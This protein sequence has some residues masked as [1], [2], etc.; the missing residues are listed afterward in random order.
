MRRMA[1]HTAAASRYRF[2]IR[3]FARGYALHTP[4]AFDTFV[5]DAPLYIEGGL[6]MRSFPQNVRRQVWGD[7]C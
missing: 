6:L 3:G 4:R 5:L 7:A 1:A 2:A